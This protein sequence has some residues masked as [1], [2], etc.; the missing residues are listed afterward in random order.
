MLKYI[1]VS[2]TF[3]LILS[4]GCVNTEAKTKAFLNQEFSLQIGQV[5]QFEKENLEI[6]FEK[7][8]E[9]SRCPKNATC[10]WAGKADCKVAV[11]QSGA[12]DSI[13]LTVR[14]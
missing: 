13:T 10:V 14:D 8:L 1:L 3:M 9:D 2:C 11:I 12:T 5:A 7:M 6:R 4:I